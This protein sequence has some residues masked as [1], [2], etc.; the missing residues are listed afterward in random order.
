MSEWP[1]VCQKAQNPAQNM[2]GIARSNVLKS[3][4]CNKKKT[5][6]RMRR[7]TPV[8]IYFLLVDATFVANCRNQRKLARQQKMSFMNRIFGTS[9]KDHHGS[10]QQHPQ[11]VNAVVNESDQDGYVHIEHRPAIESMWT[12][13]LES[14]LTGLLES[15]F[16]LNPL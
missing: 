13:V 4:E 3:C 12:Q 16:Y 6:R 2:G 14:R 1:P 10:S 5:S 15:Y 7:L 11:G 8:Y 9:K